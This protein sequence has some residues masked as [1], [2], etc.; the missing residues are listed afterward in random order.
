MSPLLIAQLVLLVLKELPDLIH[1]AQRA[2]SGATDSGPAKKAFVMQGVNLALD[3]A[4][5]T[6][7]E[8]SDAHRATITGVASTMVDTTVAAFHVYHVF[9]D[10][11]TGPD[12]DQ[13][14]AP[15]AS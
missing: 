2:F 1:A 12:S 8:I 5:A 15:Q 4:K 9:T 11:N 14:V 10:K 13:R 6:G 7:A 3:A